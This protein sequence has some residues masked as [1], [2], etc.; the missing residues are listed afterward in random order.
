MLVSLFVL[1]DASLF[2]CYNRHYYHFLGTPFTLSCSL[3]DSWLFRRAGVQERAMIML[4]SDNKLYIINLV[5]H[6]RGDPN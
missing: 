2:S 3:S 1:V 5:H 4:K 6:S